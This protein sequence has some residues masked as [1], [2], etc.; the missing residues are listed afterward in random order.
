MAT[1]KLFSLA[2]IFLVSCR[3]SEDNRQKSSNETPGGTI[4]VSGTTSEESPT[5]FK[6]SGDSV[7]VG[8]T[9]LAAS[10][11]ISIYSYSASGQRSLHSQLIVSSGT[12]TVKLDGKSYYEFVSSSGLRSLLQP[13][14]NPST[15]KTAYIRLTTVTTIASELLKIIGAK[16][17]SGNLNA[18]ENF[19]NN[20]I[21]TTD[22]VM[23]ASS[24][25]HVLDAQKQ[26]ISPSATIDLSKL[27][28]GYLIANKEK[29]ST[30][31]SQG[32]STVSYASK[33]SGIVLNSLFGSNEFTPEIRAYRAP[34]LL[35]YDVAKVTTINYQTLHPT[36][37]LAAAYA[38]KSLYRTATDPASTQTKTDIASQFQSNQLKDPATLTVT[39][40]TVD[41]GE[42]TSPES[43]SGG[44]GGTTIDPGGD[45]VTPAG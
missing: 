31:A 20:T 25:A 43:G 12:F 8:G 27:V 16:A 19:A 11:T 13:K 14:Y 32:I 45:P 38:A 41:S 30:A 22:L 2:L 39:L 26:S 23:L 17:Q 3:S 42:G 35:A 34:S 6:E 28:D 10:E 18:Q 5:D 1:L 24:V 9:N 36:A 15:T 37:P 21:A 40:P 44:E 4:E 7:Q 29:I 33:T